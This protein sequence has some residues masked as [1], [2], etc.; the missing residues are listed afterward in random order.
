MTRLRR[1]VVGSFR[2]VLVVDPTLAWIQVWWWDPFGAAVFAFPG[3]KVE[4]ARPDLDHL[5]RAGNWEPAARTCCR[6]GRDERRRLVRVGG[7]GGAAPSD[8]TSL[9]V[10]VGDRAYRRR[11]A[12]LRRTC[13]PSRSGLCVQPES[14]GNRLPSPVP[15]LR[16]SWIPGG[17]TA[18]TSRS[19][20]ERGGGD[21]LRSERCEYRAQTTREVATAVSVEGA[22]SVGQQLPQPRHPARADRV[23]HMQSQ[24]HLIDES[25]GRGEV[26]PVHRH[27]PGLR[28]TGVLRVA[29]CAVQCSGDGLPFRDGG[30][31]GGMRGECAT[32]GSGHPHRKCP[33]E[34]CGPQPGRH[35]CADGWPGVTATSRV[36]RAGSRASPTRMW[37]YS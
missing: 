31:P 12:G 16:K 3:F 2:V 8:V 7:P 32:G 9:R 18:L 4:P 19:A 15:G 27:A 6:G 20:A 26:G 21:R 28:R 37:L 10:N 30:E 36:R 11:F 22:C 34:S 29:N 35:A 25:L 23:G 17:V 1:R 33:V 14:Y 24:P 13:S 5:R